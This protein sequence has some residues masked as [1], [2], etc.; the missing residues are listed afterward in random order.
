M[1]TG[2]GG[3]R[4]ASQPKQGASWAKAQGGKGQLVWSSRGG[5]EY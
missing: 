3:A 2:A 1:W 4:E 5:R